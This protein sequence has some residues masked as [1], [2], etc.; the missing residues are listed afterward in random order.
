MSIGDRIKVARTRKGWT[1]IEVMNKTGINNK[2][3]SGYEKGTNIPDHDTIKQLAET[4]EVNPAWISGYVDDPTP[5]QSNKRKFSLAEMEK[6]IDERSLVDENGNPL[7]ES[8]YQV[9]K[10]LV[11]DYKQK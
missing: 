9:L 10:A 4:F 6:M 11:R 5:V 1:Q 3:L 7:S 8:Q 2:T